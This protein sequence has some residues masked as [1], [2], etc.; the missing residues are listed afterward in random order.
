[1]KYSSLKTVALRRHNAFEF[2]LL[3]YFEDKSVQV[4]SGYHFISLNLIRTDAITIVD[5]RAADGQRIISGD[6]Y[7][8][9]IGARVPRTA[10]KKSHQNETKNESSYCSYAC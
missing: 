1:M 6:I 4:D 7:A 2:V 5:P 8:G 9:H 10:P 3:D